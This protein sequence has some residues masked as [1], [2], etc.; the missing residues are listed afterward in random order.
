MT[1]YEIIGI[2]DV[3]YISKRTNKP[4]VGFS[5]WVKYERKDVEGVCVDNI[6]VPVERISDKPTLGDFVD[7]YYNKFGSVESVVVNRE[8]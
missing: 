6:Y 8:S 5:L 3:D 7:I 1:M 4:V 2:K